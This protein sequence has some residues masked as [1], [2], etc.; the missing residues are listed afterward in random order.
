MRLNSLSL[1]TGVI[2]VAPPKARALAYP[3]TVLRCGQKSQFHWR[4]RTL[5]LLTLPVRF[6]SPACLL[7]PH[8]LRA[9][10]LRSLRGHKHKATALSPTQPTLLPWSRRQTDRQT[11]SELACSQG[12]SSLQGQSVLVTTLNRLS[13]P[14]DVKRQAA[15]SSAAEGLGRPQ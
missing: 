8:T 10:L 13:G 4:V 12:Q 11:D 3:A 14:S 6:H 1:N 7:R 15:I 5:L 2:T 9:H